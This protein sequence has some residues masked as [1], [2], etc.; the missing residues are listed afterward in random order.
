MAGVTEVEVGGHT[1]RL[2]KLDAM[3][4]FHVSRRI[5]PLIT[6]L[7]EDGASDLI[8]RVASALG[9]LSD[10]DSEYVIAKC[11]ADCQ[12]QRNGD[13]GWAPVFRVGQ[14]MFDDIGMTGMMRL[15]WATLEGNLSDFFTALPLGS[16]AGKS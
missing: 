9:R 6:S 10:E 7:R 2:G 12:R 5:M 14:L 1:Y 15:V 3:T 16:A 13:T 8:T 4:Q 11:L